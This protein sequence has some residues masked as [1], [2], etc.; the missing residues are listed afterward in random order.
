MDD[1]RV[2]NLNKAFGD[3][4][5]LRDVSMAFPGGRRTV[6]MGDSGCGKTTLLRILMGLETRDSGEVAGVPGRVSTVFQEDRLL[7][8]F[9]AVSNIAFAADKGVTRDAILGHLAEVGLRESAFQSVSELSG[10]MRRRVAIVRAMLAKKGL[11]LMDEPFKGL[12]EHNRDRTAAYIK[13][14][15]EGVTTIIVTH[16]ADA[17]SLLDAQLARMHGHACH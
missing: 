5:V 2:T 13:R 3:H 15:S 12:D 9:S 6:V 4:I 8:E 1:V 16:D 17:A 7:E 10:G 14:Y 11:L